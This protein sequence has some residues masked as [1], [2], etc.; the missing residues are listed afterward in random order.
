[1]HW[2]TKIAHRTEEKKVSK[3]KCLRELR[4]EIAK[5]G[6]AKEYLNMP[7]TASISRW[8][9]TSLTQNSEEL[10]ADEVSEP[11]ILICRIETPHHRGTQKWLQCGAQNY[12]KDIKKPVRF[13]TTPVR[14]FTLLRPR[15]RLPQG[16]VI[17]DAFQRVKNVDRC[18]A[19]QKKSY[20]LAET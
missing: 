8:L 15:A 9:K 6:I 2:S 19:T 13:Y 17:W 7:S 1:M 12:G 18:T 4:F 14:L 11:F 20:P 5:F 3:V 10:I 16:F